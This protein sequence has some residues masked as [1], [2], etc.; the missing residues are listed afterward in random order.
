MTPPTDEPVTIKLCQARHG[1]TNWALGLLAVLHVGLLAAVLTSMSMTATATSSVKAVGA[2]VTALAARLDDI[3]DE[4][5][6]D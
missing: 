1:A 2:R 4:L 6:R 3:R 5:R